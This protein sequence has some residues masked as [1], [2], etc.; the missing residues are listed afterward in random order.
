MDKWNLLYQYIFSE[1]IALELLIKEDENTRNVTHGTDMMG[2]H[3]Y[4]LDCILQKMEELEKE[5][6][7]DEE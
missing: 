5:G 2:I 3:V 7:A 6:G 4:A 1:K